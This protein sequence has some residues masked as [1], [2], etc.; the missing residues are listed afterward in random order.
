MKMYSQYY[1]IILCILSVGYFMENTWSSHEW[2]QWIV[3][4]FCLADTSKATLS[5]R[6]KAHSC[7]ASTCLASYPP[8][9]EL[10]LGKM[11][12]YMVYFLLPCWITRGYGDLMWIWTAPFLVKQPKGRFEMIWTQKPVRIKKLNFTRRPA[13]EHFSGSWVN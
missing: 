5:T 6:R 10:S 11:S 4:V 2:N 13:V 3:S 1:D 9:T 8:K 12:K 7:L